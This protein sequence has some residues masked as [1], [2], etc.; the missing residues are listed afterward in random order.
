M[1]RRSPPSAG[2]DPAR[3]RPAGAK[4]P[5]GVSARRWLRHL[6]RHVPIA[7]EGADDEGVHQVRVA[8]GRLAV[9]LELGGRSVLRDD[10]R[11][12]RRAAAPVRD[13]DV[14]L[15]ARPPKAFAAVLRERRETGR[16]TLV[17]FLRSPSVRAL[18]QALALLPPVPR[19][20]ALAAVPRCVERVLRRGDALAA[21]PAP[22]DEDF[23][24][25]RRA[26]RKLRYALEW[27]GAD[28]GPV[29]ALQASFGDLNDLATELRVLEE[30]GAAA[31]VPA[32]A[33]ALRVRLDGCRRDA[34][35]AWLAARDGIARTT[36]R[37]GPGADGK[38]PR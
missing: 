12:L 36:V 25:L 17:P 16:R 35:A 30:T 31:V 1:T 20:T 28:A 38:A 5:R 22:H 37:A 7:I 18:R 23:H 15:A 29:R 14:L 34:L 6:A 10:L 24:R 26:L 19:R 3:A 2:S 4:R 33:A 13:A 32:H 21:L 8:A 27:L 9:W 11:A